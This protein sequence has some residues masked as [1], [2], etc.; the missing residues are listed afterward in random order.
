[1]NHPYADI[2]ISSLVHKAEISRSS[3]YLYFRDKEDMFFGMVFQM[4]S[5]LESYLEEAFKE[6]QGDFFQ[7]MLI[8]WDH[9]EQE[10]LWKDYRF[11]YWKLQTDTTCSS[12]LFKKNK[13]LGSMEIKKKYMSKFYFLIDRNLYPGLDPETFACV[14]DMGIMVILRAFFFSEDLVK[15]KE[16]ARVE[17]YILDQGIRFQDCKKQY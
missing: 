12:M 15:A 2:K 7:S 8:L 17:L 3:F 13:F 9:L 5:E 4:E 1:M 16:L 11:L 10:E 6:N 14:L